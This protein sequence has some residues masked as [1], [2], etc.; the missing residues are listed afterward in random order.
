MMKEEADERLDRIMAG[1]ERVG[2]LPMSN[3]KG[4]NPKSE[5]R[6]PK[7]IRRPKRAKRVTSEGAKGGVKRQRAKPKQPKRIAPGTKDI[8]TP[9]ATAP[10]PKAEITSGE[11]GTS[12][13]G[14]RVEEPS[15]TNLNKPEQSTFL[16]T[17]LRED[18]TVRQANSPELNSKLQMTNNEWTAKSEGRSSKSEENRNAEGANP[19]S[20]GQSEQ[21][22]RPVT[23]EDL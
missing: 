5:G 4:P 8:Q 6:S 14:S 21:K 11:T 1:E 23:E 10:V 12:G 17:P 9:E 19:K 15:E 7:E 22:R 18:A 3:V 2:E 13:A 16:M 20:E